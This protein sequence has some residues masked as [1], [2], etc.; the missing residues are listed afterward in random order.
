MNISVIIPAFNEAASIAKTIAAA[1]NQP[2]V[3]EVIV[4]D[5]QSLDQT[6]SISKVAGSAV[7]S[8]ERG[9]G[10][11]LAAGADIAKGEVLWFL[12]ADTRPESG[13]SANIIETLSD[14]R[15]VGGNFRIRFDGNSSAARFM[16]WL[17]PKLRYIGLIYGDSGIF[18]RRDVYE[19]VGGFSP[20]PLFEDLDL[21]RRLK[22]EGKILQGPGTVITSSRRFEG[23]SFTLMF[24]RWAGLQVF[25]WLGFSPNLL[26]KLYR[27]FRARDQISAEPETKRL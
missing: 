18:V 20:L 22:R 12:H 1:R 3:S 9:R 8:S 25:Y 10:K 2:N 15:N 23:K 11:Q 13:A 24:A 7:I 16:T 26:N 4:V 19:R 17:Y 6:A 21:V 5:G 14:D 27:P